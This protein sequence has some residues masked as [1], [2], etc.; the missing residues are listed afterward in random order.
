MDRIRPLLDN[1]KAIPVQT[2]FLA[3]AGGLQKAIQ[4]YRRGALRSEGAAEK[5]FQESAFRFGR[6]DFRNASPNWDRFRSFV[7]TALYR[8]IV[9]YQRR[10]QRGPQPF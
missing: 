6:G 5:G 1:R 4:R 7:K 8:W 10:V 3:S 9:D 2:P